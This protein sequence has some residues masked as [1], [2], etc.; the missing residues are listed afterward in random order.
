MKKYL[1]LFI[2]TF[3][4]IFGLLTVSYFTSEKTISVSLTKVSPS[5]A[6]SAVVCSGKVE[7]SKI[8]DVRIDK[9]SIIE[10]IKVDVGDKIEKGSCIFKLSGA[11]EGLDTSQSN[12]SPQNF[13]QQDLSK[14]SNLYEAYSSVV[15]N[16]T[17]ENFIKKNFVS[18]GK[19]REF[20]S[21]YSGIVSSISVKPKDFVDSGMCV[22][23]IASNDK[24]Q[25]KAKVNESKISDI[26]LGQK[27]IVSG[28]GFKNSKYQGHVSKISSEA[29]Q[30]LNP[31]GE[32][33]IVEVIVVIDSFAE[34]VKPGFTAKCKIITEENDGII[35]VPYESVKTDR[36]NREFV[37]VFSEDTAVKTF[38]TTGREFENGVEVVSGLDFDSQVV[39]NADNIFNGEKL[40]PKDDES[41]CS[42]Q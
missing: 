32:E 6:E 21:P 24:L 35:I 20:E 17:K 40:L 13:S 29:K 5:K 27:V 30:I 38:I 31:S 34:D 15:S 41:I 3:V 37:Y 25:V 28:T 12:V 14:F 10:E 26:K 39:S 1:V 36:H 16:Q 11:I 19:F 7:Y 8:N 9:H 23:S 2:T 33:T 22:C 18:D 42:I 4:T